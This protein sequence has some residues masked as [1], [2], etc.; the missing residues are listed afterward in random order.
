MP[1]AA[2]YAVLRDCLIFIIIALAVGAA[3]YGYIRSA[4]L[5]PVLGEIGRVPCRLFSWQEALFAGCLIALLSGTLIEPATTTDAAAPA[6]SAVEISTLLQGVGVMLFLALLVLVFLR[7]VRDHD[8]GDLFGLRHMS[9]SSAAKFALIAILPAW[10]LTACASLAT[11]DLIQ[12]IWP[13]MG[14]QDTVK[15]FK[16]T[17]DV[18]VRVVMI[19]AAVISAP[20]TEEVI[21]RGFFYPVFKRFTDAWLAAPLNALLFA[22]VHQ[23]VG[24]FIP[25]FVLALTMI[26]AYELSGCLLVP[27]FMHAAFNGIST[28]LLLSDIKLP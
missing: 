6:S 28:F 7:I 11:H 10:I 20:L 22:L 4:S 23:H 26:V 21:F 1:D 25:L 2:T 27:I 18:L 14:P 8:L 19:F 3:V 15:S 9:I 12:A 16:E 13:D 5:T 24:S 17:S